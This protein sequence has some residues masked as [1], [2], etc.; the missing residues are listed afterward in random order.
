MISPARLA[1]PSSSA[2]N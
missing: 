1:I 2:I